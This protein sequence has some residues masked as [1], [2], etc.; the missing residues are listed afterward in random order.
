MKSVD[1]G[2]F[3]FFPGG[4]GGECDNGGG[5][6]TGVDADL[7]EDEV[8]LEELDGIAVFLGL[9]GGEVTGRGR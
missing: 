3:S 2:S 7:L 6:L 4:C 8:R 5:D 9:A 1:K